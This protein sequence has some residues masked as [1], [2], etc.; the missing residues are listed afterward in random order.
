MESADA[1]YKPVYFYLIKRDPLTTA[2]TSPFAATIFSCRG[3]F[4]YRA[5]APLGIA[6]APS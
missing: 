1:F 5:I 3:L 4:V 6:S 2:P